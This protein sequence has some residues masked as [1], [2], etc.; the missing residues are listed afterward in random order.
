MRR[1]AK[2]DP[3]AVRRS[4]ARRS[5]P[6]VLLAVLLA[7]IGIA[8]SVQAAPPEP[9]QAVHFLD[10]TTLSW[11][12][13]PTPDVAAYNV[14]GNAAPELATAC[15]IGSVPNT[16]VVVPDTPSS[17]EAIFLLV[18]A[19]NADGEGELGGAGETGTRTANPWCR[20]N[21]R[22]YAVSG[23][24]PNPV[25][26]VNDGTIP[27]FSAS[28][29]FLATPRETTGVVRSTGELFVEARDLP[30]AHP[31]AL[32][33]P[34]VRTY[35][36]MVD[37]ITPL[38]HNWFH[39]EFAKLTLANPG[40]GWDIDFHDG[41]GRVERFVWN[42]DHYD[43]PDGVFA[44]LVY[45]H[46]TTDY[47]LR[48][49]DGTIMRFYAPEGSTN[50]AGLLQLVHDR[51][52]N[53]RT[54][55]Y[56]AEAM[57]VTTVD[58]LGR[59]TSWE[60]DAE[61]RLTRIADHTGREVSYTYDGNDDLDSV[62]TPD[63]ATTS[64]SYL[65]GTPSPQ[66]EHNLDEIVAPSGTAHVRV[67]YHE[68][69]SDTFTLDR[70]DT[71][72]LGGT[73]AS[74][75]PAGGHWAYAYT[76]Y[77]SGSTSPNP[78]LERRGTTVTDGSGDEKHYVFNRY[79]H[80]LTLREYTNRDVRPAEVDEYT[81]EYRVSMDGKILQIDHPD[82]RKSHYT[83]DDAS[84][85]RYSQGNL[86]EK[87][88]EP[89]P[90]SSGLSDLVWIYEYEPLNN[91]IAKVTDPRETYPGYVPQN[92]GS[93]TPGRYTSSWT[94]DWQEMDPAATWLQGYLD[95]YGIHLGSYPHNLGDV[96]G[97]GTSDL[98]NGQPVVF[99]DVA[100]T[101]ESGS[102]QAAIEG[103]LSQDRVT[104]WSWNAKGQ[105][106]ERIDPEGNVDT[107]VYN[108]ELDPD[109]DGAPTP[110]PPD[111]RELDASLGGYLKRIW[112]DTASDPERNN[113][114]HTTP[115]NARIEFEYDEVGN[116]TRGINGRGVATSADY[117]ALRRP[118]E[119]RRASATKTQSEV[120]GEPTTGYG[121]DGLDP[122]A[123][124]IQIDY[125]IDGYVERVAEQDVTG[126]HGCGAYVDHHLVND[127]LGRVVSAEKEVTDTSS[128][129]TQYRYTATGQ[130][131][132]I[133]L[134]SGTQHTV[135]YD[136][137]RLPYRVTLG[138]GGTAAATTYDYDAA[139]RVL[140][141]TTPTG[142]LIDFEYD[143]H[144]RRIL[145]RDQIGGTHEREYDPVGN[146]TR[147][148]VRGTVSGSPTDRSGSSNVDL[149]DDRYNFDEANR[150]FRI[151]RLVYV[152]MGTPTV[153]VPLLWEGPARVG[154]GAINTIL[155]YDRAD[156]QTFRIR[157][158]GKTIRT[159]WNG[160]SLPWRE[161][162]AAVYRIDRTF[163]AN[164][165]LVETKQIEDS[166]LAGPPAETFFT[167]HFYDA[168]DRL[169][170]VV[171]NAG[172]TTDLRYTH[173]GYLAK[174]SDPKGPMNGERINRRTEGHEGDE[175]EIND[176]GNVTLHFYDGLGRPT[177]H[178]QLITPDAEGDG[179]WSPVLDV[180]N[181]YNP[182]GAIEVHLTWSEDG[183][184]TSWTGDRGN[185]RTFTYDDLG[186]M[187]TRAEADGSTHTY[188]WNDEGKLTGE[189]HPTGTLVSYALD[190]KGRRLQA[191]V[192]RGAGVGGTTQQTFVW[193]GFDMIVQTTDDNDPLDGDDDL[194]A[195]FAIDSLARVI[196][197]QDRMPGMASGS[198]DGVLSTNWY[199]LDQVQKEWL[200]SGHTVTFVDDDRERLVR[201]EVG[202]A[203]FHYGL[204][205]T[206]R[207]HTLTYPDGCDETR[208]DATGTLD[209]GYDDV[210]RTVH[211]T[212]RCPA[213]D[214]PA[215]Y[216]QSFDRAGHRTLE[217][218]FHW[219]T[220][221][222][223]MGWSF[224]H[225]SIGSV[226]REEFGWTDAW[227]VPLPDESRVYELDGQRNVPHVNIDGSG[228]T[229][230]R[231][232][233]RDC[234]SEYPDDGVPDDFLDA[235][236]TSV[237]DGTNLGY[238]TRGH[239]TQRGSRR[240][241][242]D[243]LGRIAEVT[244]EG[245]G[246]VLATY[247][248]HALGQRGWRTADHVTPTEIRRTFWGV[249]GYS[250]GLPYE[251][252]DGSHELV[253]RYT[254]GPEGVLSYTPASGPIRYVIHDALGLV[255][256]VRGHAV[257][258]DSQVDERVTYDHHGRPMFR[259][260][261]GDP[262]IDPPYDGSGVGNV[263]I[264]AGMLYDTEFSVRDFDT[265]DD[266]P[267]L[268]AMATG[269]SY[270][271]MRGRLG[272]DAYVGDPSQLRTMAAGQAARR[273]DPSI[274]T[275]WELLPIDVPETGPIPKGGGP[276]PDPRRMTDGGLRSWAMGA[277]RFG[278][279]P[280][281][282]GPWEDARPSSHSFEPIDAQ[283]VATASIHG[284]GATRLDDREYRC[285]SGQRSVYGPVRGIQ[286]DL[287]PARFSLDVPDLRRSVLYSRDQWRQRFARLRRD[288]LAPVDEIGTGQ[289]P[290][291]PSLR[292]GRW[293]PTYARLF[294]GEGFLPGRSPVP[295]APHFERVADR[296][297]TPSLVWRP[298][299]S[300]F[301]DMTRLPKNP[302]IPDGPWPPVP[303]PLPP[304]EPLPPPPF[305]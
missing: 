224:R 128:L 114:V 241:R 75:V 219:D 153:R 302:R 231:H 47:D 100:V 257:T 96:N 119:I 19:Y 259:T 28:A 274:S 246:D 303:P 294:D 275:L 250:A 4:A 284:G 122:T 63:G 148:V 45:N 164:G 117:D 23:N 115:V 169:N 200:P 56:D 234:G 162:V 68:N 191:D 78:D 76:A 42:V 295:D 20:P 253:R 189:S 261:A 137:R 204:F 228:Y 182:D 15:L 254:H 247:A 188:T 225:D 118:V 227:G 70:V 112:R 292:L 107:F 220:G 297:A 194:E 222:G 180:T 263:L 80:L 103:D 88:V 30:T 270:D 184:L 183:H 273:Y 216:G 299:S 37:A 158:S 233:Q 110:A 143:D 150:L 48:W 66:L 111:G 33:R 179:T 167:T 3:T 166:N 136:E 49:P 35:R 211:L 104:R 212:T 1:F 38:G 138:E 113:K 16:S 74:G 195:Y 278:T 237:A 55:I 41:T 207:V 9:P 176:L 151:D 90:G 10:E 160:L 97:D 120:P 60:Y 217:R 172:Q 52:N 83:Y 129:T 175:E 232:A 269:Q 193:N 235:D 12:P 280:L 298:S 85:N 72:D 304:P 99:E 57:L 161:S 11:T 229:N 163:D 24:V 43:S 230:A 86:L 93:V 18:S 264:H 192:T 77:N 289:K 59:A 218:H 131:E 139:K 196:E 65:V 199:G 159:D 144:G 44:V 157:D 92:G 134:P 268:Y 39:S 61:G 296:D 171:D 101:L 123:D 50:V 17:G 283:Q 25:D 252:Y 26:G 300:D 256:G 201:I 186:R 258:D 287:R 272:N 262:S 54:F 185:T 40:G 226:E 145:R 5:E 301:M 14:Y 156:R 240:I 124:R 6:L 29:E 281:A 209:I 242:R 146:V 152:P 206:S 155:E 135:I 121:E 94:Y 255:G 141:V 279:R 2:E 177:R 62:T 208:L 82:G 142:E 249:N 202:S 203:N 8:G 174:I 73:N 81:T 106:V 243:F 71:Q 265:E 285:P 215:E 127:L 190:K 91:R 277:P 260:A 223:P 69:P 27:R 267:G 288:D 154:D 210:K 173:L 126:V 170:R 187:L 276:I 271:P 36:S 305:R 290:I 244:E 239:L 251:T 51:A 116:V 133:I 64:Y 205:G 32:D 178:R 22:R 87:R 34:G 291:S 181:P 213:G 108:A 221:S 149:S 105:L 13:P 58:D 89:A 245:S 31:R 282:R 95:F 165:N 248:Y 198:H 236:A 84:L 293:D 168:H 53:H 140:T 67:D 214:P 130:R 266:M 46:D 147:R 109:G 102:N 79:G 21:R 7:C 286:A 132:R 98:G 125:D 238:D 197:V